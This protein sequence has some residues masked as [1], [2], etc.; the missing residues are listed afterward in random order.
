MLVYVIGLVCEKHEN[1]RDEWMTNNF[2]FIK[3]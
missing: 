3:I 2:I 1:Y